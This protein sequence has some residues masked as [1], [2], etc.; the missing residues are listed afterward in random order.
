MVTTTRRPTRDLNLGTCL[1][2]KPYGVVTSDDKG[3]FT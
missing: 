2:H 1:L 3:P